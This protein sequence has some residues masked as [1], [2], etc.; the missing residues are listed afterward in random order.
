MTRRQLL[1]ASPL[2]LAAQTQGRPPNIVVI[3]ADDL[4]YGDLSCYGAPDLQTPHIDA[5]AREGMRFTHFYANSPVCSP[6]RAALL[7]G[8]SPDVVGVP[9]VIRTHANN[10]WGYLDP[11]VPLLPQRLRPQ[12][13]RTGIVGKWHLGLESPNL[14]NERGFETFHGFLGDMMDDYQNHRRHGINY[15]RH[16][17]DEIDPAGHATEL[18]TS[19]AVEYVKQQRDTPFLLYLAFNAPH[20]P[21]QPPAEWL[22][23][24]TARNPAL[25]PA[26]AKIAALIEHMDDGVGRVVQTLKQQG[27]YDNTL[28]I[29]TSD[30]GGEARAGGTVGGLRGNKQDLYEG[31]IRVPAVFVWPGQIR[32]GTT[33][34]LV[35]QSSDLLPTLCEAAGTPAGQVDGTSIL[36]TLLGRPQDLSQRTLFWVRR[37][38]SVPYFGQDYY[39]AR[40]GPWKL[41]Q[42]TPFQ[43]YELYHLQEDPREQHNVLPAQPQ[44]GRELMDALSLQIQRA[45]R[46]PWQR[47]AA[48]N[49]IA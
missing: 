39:A 20:V 12:R 26:R 2:P 3:L 13:Y 30:N 35:A 18:F 1:A 43:P 9:G 25:P 45:G 15:L 34:E 48:R 36:P 4:G 21:I 40:R 5:L 31:G 16:N 49:A 44:I 14:P 8:C 10:S 28:L 11:T 17:R 29:F 37:E 7:T 42:N 19:W 6:T 22:A 46:V 47:P 38:G 27:L 23:R 41:L 33:S 24:V 32:P